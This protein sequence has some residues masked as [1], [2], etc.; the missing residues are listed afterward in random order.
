[1][2]GAKRRGIPPKEAITGGFSQGSDLFTYIVAGLLIGLGLDWL[3]GWRPVMTI[4]WSLIGIAV[5][6]Y[7]MWQYSAV[8]EDE[9][10]GRSHG[11]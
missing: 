6:V 1:M 4:I 5:G 10:K 7:R 2:D 9:A 3:T 11:V 8:L